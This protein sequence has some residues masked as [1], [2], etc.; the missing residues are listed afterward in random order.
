MR[1]SSYKQFDIVRE[2]SPEMF[3]EKLNEKMYERR[4]NWPEVTFSEEG[5][6]LIAR[7]SYIR[8]DQVPE[9]LGDVYEM[10]DVRF[11]CE[12]CPMFE[13]IHN[14]NGSLNMRVKY[15]DCPHSKFG[16]T[17]KDSRACDLLYMMLREGRIHLVKTDE[18]EENR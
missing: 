7:I 3:T 15:G 9:D 13:P 1:T 17:Y 6:W 11:K 4:N 12:D 18:E 10:M 16:R 14:K 5:K 2:D 8:H